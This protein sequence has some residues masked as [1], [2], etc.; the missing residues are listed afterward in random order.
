[1]SNL[2]RNDLLGKVKSV[3]QTKD[4]NFDTVNLVHVLLY[5][6]NDL[7]SSDNRKILEYT[8]KFIALS[9]RLN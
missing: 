7:S 5:G 4:I 8:I 3:L 1:M 6:H 2:I 9:G